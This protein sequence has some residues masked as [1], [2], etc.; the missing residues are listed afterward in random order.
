MAGVM[1][2]QQ[3]QGIRKIGVFVMK[4]LRYC[5]GVCQV[6]GECASISGEVCLRE[7]CQRLGRG[8]C[9]VWLCLTG[10]TAKDGYVKK[11]SDTLNH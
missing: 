2:A 10:S 9:E 4:E 11:T 6:V 3:F 5:G 1:A 8:E 7:V